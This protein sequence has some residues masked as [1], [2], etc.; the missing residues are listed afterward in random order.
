[1]S[2]AVVFCTLPSTPGYALSF[3]F[4]FSNTT[5]N[6]SGTVTGVVEGL[7]DNTANQAASAV[8]ITS[9]LAIYQIPTPSFTVPFGRDNSFSV[10]NGSITAADFGQDSIFTPAGPVTLS[11]LTTIGFLGF[12]SNEPAFLIPFTQG[13]ISYV[14]PA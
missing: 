11:L 9:A 8:I 12:V 13:P 3:D 14:V 10:A 4:S 1:M 6:T 2:E 5:G 7:V